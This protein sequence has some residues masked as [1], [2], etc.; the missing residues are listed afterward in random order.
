MNLTKK[1][2]ALTK[3]AHWKRSS[4]HLRPERLLGPKV[5]A[6]H[7]CGTA[8]EEGAAHVRVLIDATIYLCPACA[9]PEERDEPESEGE[10]GGG[11]SDGAAGEVHDTG[12]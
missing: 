3:T 4:A 8:V 7:Y 5:V 11:G 2:R 10:R 12:R 6:C 1:L 9:G